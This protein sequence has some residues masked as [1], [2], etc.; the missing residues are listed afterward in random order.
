[1][2]DIVKWMDGW[3]IGGKISIVWF[4]I[5]S[6]AVV[7]FSLKIVKNA[8]VL[9]VKT[10]FAGGFIGGVMIAVISAAPEFITS[11]QQSIIGDPGAA[12]SDDVGANILAGST[13]G[14]AALLFLRETFMNRLKKWT[15][16][17]LWLSFAFS[18]LMMFVMY[19]NADVWLGSS[20]K[21]VIGL[22]PLILIISYFILLWAQKKFGDDDEHQPEGEYIDKTSV[23]QASIRFLVWGV[24]LII[25]SILTN[26]SVVSMEHGYSISPE[27]AGGLFLALT[28]ALP[29]TVAFFALM[30]KG[31][32]AMAVAVLA[33]HG[34]ALFVSEFLADASYVDAPTYVTEQVHNV[35]PLA[36]M[37]AISFGFLGISALVGKR[38]KIFQRN[39]IVYSIL[40]ALSFLTYVIGWI[41]LL[42]IWY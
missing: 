29:E 39:K 33:G 27:S 8:E 3:N 20:G 6:A 5:F 25:A 35:W 40:P 16:I 10:K 13:I 26:F 22:F 28:M 19:F 12:V 23:R 2:N 15:I 30:K 9:S 41:L 21:F 31:Q 32:K 34:F 36:M 37:A 7:F 18:L 11:I 1:M 14:L 38:F 24:L 42:T 17:T 4:L